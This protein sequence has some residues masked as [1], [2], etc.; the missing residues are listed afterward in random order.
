MGFF[1]SEYRINT[2]SP[3]AGKLTGTLTPFQKADQ[4]RQWKKALNDPAHRPYKWAFY[5][6]VA[7]VVVSMTA[8]FALI[9]AA[10]L[11]R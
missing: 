7:M 9:I 10:L 6:L 2:R 11:L 5:V 4:R 3:Y 8:G 1:V